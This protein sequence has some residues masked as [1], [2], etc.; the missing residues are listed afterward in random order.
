VSYKVLIAVEIKTA[1]A[2]WQLPRDLLIQVYEIGS[3]I[4]V[5]CGLLAAGI[6]K[7]ALARTRAETGE[8]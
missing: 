4:N 3:T 2:S 6:L 8:R 5:N 7:K 1:S